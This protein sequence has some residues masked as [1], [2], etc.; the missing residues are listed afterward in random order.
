VVVVSRGRQAPVASGAPAADLKAAIR[1]ELKADGCTQR[2]LA[3]YLGLSEKH[4]SGVLSGRVVGAWGTLER[5]AAAV[6][7]SVGVEQGGQR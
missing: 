4:V 2:D 3:R 7:L 6:G 5:M 1:R